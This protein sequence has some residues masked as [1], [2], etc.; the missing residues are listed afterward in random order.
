M[1]FLTLSAAVIFSVVAIIAFSSN[2]ATGIWSLAAAGA[3]LA[4]W[5]VYRAALLRRR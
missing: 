1:K 4:T 2:L 5:S 3:T